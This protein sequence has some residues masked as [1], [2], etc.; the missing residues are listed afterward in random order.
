MEE[1]ERDAKHVDDD[2]EY[3]EHVVSEGAVHQ[4]TAGRVVV[5]LWVGGQRTAQKSRTQIDGDAGEP[6]HEGAEEHALRRVH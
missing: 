4:G 3:V 1:C 6:D 2:P 5:D